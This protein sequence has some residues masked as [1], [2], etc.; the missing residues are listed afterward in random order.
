[1][2][3]PTIEQFR[4]TW[5]YNPDPNTIDPIPDT[6]T[7]AANKAS[8]E[9]GYPEIT[10]RQIADAGEPP[11][12]QDTNGILNRLS[13]LAVWNSVGGTFP[14]NGSLYNPSNPFITGYPE[15]ARIARADKTGYWINTVDDNQTDPDSPAAV[16]WQPESNITIATVTL[17]TNAQTSYTL[18]KEEAARK[19][20][21]VE[22][23]G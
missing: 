19:L 9:K 7:G 13:Q 1:M 15:G 18:S 23:A 10:M 17:N 20:I 11:T 22:T 21:L 5:A 12:G 4:T 16:G 14:Y 8:F 6:P 3:I 2:P